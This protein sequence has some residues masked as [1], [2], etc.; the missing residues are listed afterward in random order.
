MFPE[1]FC[2]IHNDIVRHDHYFIQKQDAV[3]KWGLS[4]LQK[5]VAAWRVLC[6]G[7]SADSVDENLRIGETTTLLCL[8]RVCDAIID[9][10]EEEFFRKPKPA[11]IHRILA[12]NAV[13]GFPGMFGSLDCMHWYWHMCP[14]GWAGMFK[15]GKEKWP[16][17]VLE[18]VASYDLWIWHAVFGIP[19]SNNDVNILNKSPISQQLV[20]GTFPKVTFEVNGT[21]FDNMYLLVDGIYPEWAIFVKTFAQPQD[22]K[23]AHFSKMQEG[24]RKDVERCFGVLQA[25]F[26]ILKKPSKYWN[27]LTMSKIMKACCIIHNMIID[28]EREDLDLSLDYDDGRDGYIIFRDSRVNVERIGGWSIGIRNQAQDISEGAGYLSGSVQNIIANYQRI[29]SNAK[30]YEL[31]NALI[32]FQWNHRTLIPCPTINR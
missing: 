10:Y 13:R 26:Q 16:S 7:Q 19:G 21:E 2:K 30:H 31:R 1:L 8:K 18:A 27:H 29:E 32:D 11:D 28:D 15:N 9:L 5:I 17:F 20:D 4:S 22:Q 3:G 25:R 23:R 14:K 12:A 6:Y 24:A